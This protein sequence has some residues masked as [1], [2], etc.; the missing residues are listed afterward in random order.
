MSLKY[1]AITADTPKQIV[2]DAGVVYRNFVSPSEPGEL[3]GA[4]RGGSEFNLTLEQREIE[5]DG[6]P[7]P[8]KG[9]KRIVRVEAT[10]TVNMLALSLDN[11][12]A[13]IAGGVSAAGGTDFPDHSVIT[14]KQITDASYFDN[15]A[16]VA[17]TGSGKPAIFVIENALADGNLS[18]SLSDQDEANPSVTFVAHFDPAD[19]ETNADPFEALP[20][21]IYWPE[22]T[23]P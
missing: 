21:K 2:F 18:I 15:L 12:K 1:H 14:G 22:T 3:I 7:G 23:T 13:A 16:L 20:F 19:L 9:F 6:V 8:L 4:T 11:L 17:R 5:A 10:L